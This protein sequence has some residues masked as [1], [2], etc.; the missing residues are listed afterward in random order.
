M[1][2][3]NLYYIFYFLN[4]F[5]SLDQTDDIIELHPKIQEITTDINNF[6]DLKKAYLELLYKVYQGNYESTE[7]CILAARN[8]DTNEINT[9][10]LDQFPGVAKEYISSDSVVEYSDI[11]T[12]AQNNKTNSNND[13]SEEDTLFP[14]EFLNTLRPSGFPPHV[15]KL[16]VL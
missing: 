8:D 7:C 16:K 14:V 10:A 5:Y 1:F 4:I 12:S 2:T 15:L 6:N 9:L 3:N 11:K 13:K